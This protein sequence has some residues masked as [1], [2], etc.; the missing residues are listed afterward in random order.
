MAKQ[1]PYKDR[2]ELLQGTLD[3]LILQLLRWAP[4]HGYGIAK[5]FEQ[6]RATFSR[7]KQG[8]CI[9]RC[10]ALRSAAGSKSEWGT[11][12]NNQRAKY[13]QLTAAGKKHLTRE[14]GRWNQMAGAIASL[15]KSGQK[16]RQ[17]M[18]AFD[19]LFRPA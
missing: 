5:L 13:Y 18:K 3:M 16:W 2:I 17:S 12:E 9:R 1:E 7:W 10:I 15:I 11:T 19:W 8:R 14:H 6:G 4:Q